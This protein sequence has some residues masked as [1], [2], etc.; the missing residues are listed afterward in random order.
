MPVVM[1]RGG[2][3]ADLE[4][5]AKILAVLHDHLLDAELLQALVGGGHANQAAP[6]PGHE[7]DGGGRDAFGG[8]DEVAFVF[9]VGIIHHDDHPAFAEI[10]DDGFNGVERLFHMQSK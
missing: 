6:V 4:I 7:I 5:R 9:A 10:G 1:P 2:I 3:D 8:H